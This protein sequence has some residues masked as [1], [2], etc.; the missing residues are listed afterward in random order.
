MISSRI[1]CISVTIHLSR[2]LSER[3]LFP[4]GA[5][6][7]SATITVPRWKVARILLALLALLCGVFPASA[8]TVK[9]GGVDRTFTFTCPG[10]GCTSH[11]PV[12][13]GF[14]GRYQQ[15]SGFKSHADFE[16]RGVKA[17]FVYPLGI[18]SL[19]PSWNA[20]AEPPQVPAEKNG[21]DDVG[22]VEAVIAYLDAKYRIDHSRIF[23]TGMSNGGQFAWELAC[24]TDIFA[25]IA[26]VS[27]TMNDPNCPP[28]SHPPILVIS[29]TS[30]KVELWDGGGP[31]GDAPFQVEIDLF[32]AAKSRVTALRPSGG[33]TWEQ[34]DIDTTGEVL[35]FFGLL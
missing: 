8:V 14:H 23:A 27:G 1:C 31:A 24:T 2:N 21:V 34:P 11:L 10:D 4:P 28:V 12:V 33:H 5:Y 6:P 20:G 19:S 7:S 29:G 18:P 30:D 9:V 25:A 32:R 13:F 35:R 17:I 15:P 22:F 26:S 3:T 16:S